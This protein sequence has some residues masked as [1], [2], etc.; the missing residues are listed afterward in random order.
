MRDEFLDFEPLLE[1]QSVGDLAIIRSIL[2]SEGITY[3]I[4]NEHV[5]QYL[6]HSVPMRILVYTEEA[7]K[8]R[9]LLKDV[10]LSSAYAGLKRFQDR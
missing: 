3:Y 5:A 6:Y 7:D 8:A 2:D 4:Q 1:T 9:E 10:K